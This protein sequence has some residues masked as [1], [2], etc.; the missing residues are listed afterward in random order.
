[1][2]SIALD[3]GIKVGN[4]AIKVEHL[5]KYYDLGVI[6]SGTLRKDL[7]SWFWK[8]RGREDPNSRIGAENSGADGFWALKDIDFEIQQGDRVGIVGK[9]GAGKST[10]LKMISQ[11]SAPTKGNIYIKGKVAS[12]LEV[13]TGF[14][15]ELT[16][17]ENIYMNGAIL[18]MKKREIDRKMDEIIDFSGIE[19]HIDTPVKRYSSGMYVRL[20]FAVAA[21]LDSD[22]LITDEVLAV[23][24]AEFQRKALGKMTELSTGEGRTVLFVSHNM[25]A[26]EMLCNK[27]FLMDHGKLAS[28]GEIHEITEK[29]LQSYRAS[30]RQDIAVV[31]DEAVR[32][33][34]GAVDFTDISFSKDA[35]GA[36]ED[37]VIDFSLKT[38]K[39]FQGLYMSLDVKNPRREFI[40]S[41]RYCLEPGIVPEGFSASY[42]ITISG[43]TLLP[44]NYPLYFWLGDEMSLS[45]PAMNYCVL[46]EYTPDLVITAEEGASVPAA[47]FRLQG[48]LEKV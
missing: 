15:Q 36:D 24:D 10:L 28:R 11:I 27:G 2:A 8:R 34:N 39:S 3:A 43:G 29:Y 40:S 13:G 1:M 44:G 17:R 38:S 9:N 19:K 22:I 30:Y 7:Q 5:S 14:N 45:G 35:Y 42:R 46:D 33:G 6:G 20:A 16:G 18:G 12:L 47:L 32:R 31:R 4:V 21:H 25:S 48:R 26:V 23:G 41:L 37:I